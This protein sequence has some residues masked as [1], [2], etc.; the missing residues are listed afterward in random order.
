M[1]SSAILMHRHGG[2]EVL[3]QAVVDVPDPGPGELLLRQRAIG[4]NFAEVYQRQGVAGPH[5]VAH[6]P[7]IPGSQGAGVVMAVGAGVDDFDI[8][9]EVACIH[10]GAYVEWRVIPAARAVKLSSAAS[11]ASAALSIE[12]AA[13][14]LLRGMTAEYLLHRLFVVKPGDRVLVHAAAGGMG[15]ILVQ[16]ARGLGAVV[17]GTVGSPGKID[18]ARAHG[19]H[20][21]VDYRSDDFVAKVNQ[22]TEGRGVA[23]VYDGVGK[24]VFVPSLD[25]L[26]TRG[27]I[28][29]YGTASG[30]VEGFDLQRLH[31]KS[32][33]VCR[34]TLKSFI[35]TT[36]ELR[37]S[38][39]CFAEAVARGAVRP[40]IN[41]RYALA[42]VQRAHTELESRAMTGSAILVP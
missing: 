7:V 12:T 25:C 9:D 16:W 14:T 28:I 32:L 39:A 23:V 5:Q 21:V 30:Q 38:A 1:H 8:G 17:I 22:F 19:C 35:A 40:A 18:L 33:T 26:Q 4:L 27:M 6:F 29:S 41:R 42:D 15:E 11:T 13:A 37:A 24:D 31:A 3:E 20:H 34:P 10:P 2:P 36:D